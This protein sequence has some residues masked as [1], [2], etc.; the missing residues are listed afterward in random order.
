M[1]WSWK[2]T[3]VAGIDIK[4]HATFLLIFAWFGISYYVTGGTL[5]AALSGIAFL[6]AVF[7]FVVLHELGHALTARKFGIKT[8]DI[9]LLP[10][11]GLARIEKM[12]DKPIEEFWVAIAGPAVN[13]FLAAI[14]AAAVVLSG[15][16]STLSLTSLFSLNSGSLLG[17]L[18][19]VNL[20]LGLFN[21]IPAFPMDG[22]RILRAL[23]ATQMPYARATRT[24]ASVGQGIAF[25]FGLVGLFTDPMLLFIAFFVYI[26]AAAEASTVETKSALSGATVSSAMLTEYH[27][28]SEGDPLSHA[29]NLI[30]SGSQAE[31]PV[32][33][34]ERVV[35]ILTRKGLIEAIRRL[36]E[37]APVSAAMER[38]FEAVDTNDPLETVSSKLQSHDYHTLPVVHNDQLVGL[39]TMENIGEYMMIHSA[40]ESSKQTPPSA[41]PMP[42]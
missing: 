24:A 9:T 7:G 42:R 19:A 34:G 30:M 38:S 3:R 17:R 29:I 2:I 27:S 1:R 18:A 16:L 40:L 8:T 6:M 10:I 20:F 33:S 13:F 22:G 21:L 15:N 23:L 26:G 36:G 37:R 12:P 31:F 35:G 28:L 32:I 39:I 14:F 11:G 5:A 25:L 4:I 41:W